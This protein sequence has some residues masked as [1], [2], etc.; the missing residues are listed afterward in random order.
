MARAGESYPAQ[1]PLFSHGGSHA[2]QHW[3][4]SCDALYSTNGGSG[5]GSGSGWPNSRRCGAESSFERI[6]RSRTELLA[7]LREC[8]GNA[9]GSEV[10]LPRRGINGD[11]ICASSG[12]KEEKIGQ[13]STDPETTDKKGKGGESDCPC[14]ASGGFVGER[15]DASAT[16]AERPMDTISPSWWGMGEERA[17][18]Q[19]MDESTGCDEEKRR[20]EGE[21]AGEEGSIGTRRRR[22][23]H[24]KCEASTTLQETSEATTSEGAAFGPVATIPVSV[25]DNPE[26]VGKQIGR[27]ER[28]ETREQ[29]STVE[30]SG[31]E[32]VA[33]DSP[34][35]QRSCEG[36]IR[37]S[38][39]TR[40]SE[41]AVREV[42]YGSTGIWEHGRGEG[43]RLKSVLSHF[44]PHY[45]R[46][47]FFGDIRNYRD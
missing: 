23:S 18:T 24:G 5:G 14:P 3:P 30:K 37:D 42:Q 32:D 46:H 47:C 29:A 35:G 31:G 26:S 39:P 41:E 44:K 28:T 34:S 21:N 11:I 25:E 36:A 8:E 2:Y 12:E 38:A 7:A 22:R 13:R 40:K 45:Y 19:A 10:S 6:L 1:S 33:N 17:K 4:T 15:R 20:S 43:K 9:P 27:E 16:T